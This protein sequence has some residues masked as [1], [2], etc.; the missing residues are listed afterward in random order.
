MK[1]TINDFKI[2]IKEIN[3]DVWVRDLI[4]KNSNDKYFP[5][6]SNY[7][8]EIYQ[9][10]LYIVKVSDFEYHKLE[11]DSNYYNIKIYSKNGEN[12]IEGSEEGFNNIL[13]DIKI[14]LMEVMLS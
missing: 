5:H 3:P 8:I 11:F 12:Y 10:R 14:K 6:I 4:I 13:N 1:M 2:R 9:E 7:V